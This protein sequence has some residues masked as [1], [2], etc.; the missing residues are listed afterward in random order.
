MIKVNIPKKEIINKFFNPISRITDKCILAVQQ[1]NISAVTNT[2]DG[3]IILY[4]KY[5]TSTSLDENTIIK[6]NMPDVKKLTKMLECISNTET[7]VDLSIE[8]NHIAYT[9]TDLKFKYYL[10]DDGIIQNS[11]INVDKINKLTFDTNFTITTQKLDEILKASSFNSDCN[12]IYF[13]TKDNKVYGE[14]TDKTIQNID[15]IT[16]SISDSYSGSE[17]KRVLPIDLEII[18]MLGVVK[19]N[20]SCKIN[21]KLEVLMFEINE[22]NLVLKYIVSALTK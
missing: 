2:D 13:Y 9:G 7:N 8:S 1:N 3:N 18:R 10:L 12:K 22:P 5:N 20:I 6:I 15:N 4:A 19:N 14:I 11:I 16:F 17:T 21:T